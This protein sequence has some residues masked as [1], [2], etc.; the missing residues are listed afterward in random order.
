[1]IILFD[2]YIQIHFENFLNRFDVKHLIKTI[3]TQ[4]IL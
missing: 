4:T 2:K 1:M 3:N